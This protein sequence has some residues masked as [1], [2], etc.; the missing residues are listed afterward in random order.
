[1]DASAKSLEDAYRDEVG[2]LEAAERE[3]RALAN[4]IMQLTTRV[5]RLHIARQEVAR[6]TGR[7]EPADALQHGPVLV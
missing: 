2:A 1:M 4:T 5:E 3:I 6:V 7:P